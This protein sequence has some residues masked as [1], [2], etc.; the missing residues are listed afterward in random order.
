MQDDEG[1][2]LPLCY[3]TKQAKTGGL[4]K[5]DGISMDF[6]QKA[7][8]HPPYIV[9]LYKNVLKRPDLPRCPVLPKSVKLTFYDKNRDNFLNLL[10][11]SLKRKGWLVPMKTTAN[12]Q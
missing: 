9:D 3:L 11:E 4:F 10:L 6:E 1:V 5:K 7:N 2:E 8:D 12:S